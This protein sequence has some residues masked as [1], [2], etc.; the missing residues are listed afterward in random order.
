[1]A[2][3]LHHHS[4]YLKK[5]KKKKEYRIITLPC[6]SLATA[7]LKSMRGAWRNALKPNLSMSYDFWW[8]NGSWKWKA[9]LQRVGLPQIFFFFFFLNQHFVCLSLSGGGKS[10]CPQCNCSLIGSIWLDLP[11]LVTVLWA[12]LIVWGKKMVVYS[13][14]CAPPFSGGV[15]LSEVI[16][17][18][19]VVVLVCFFMH[20][21]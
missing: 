16:W 5:K 21:P 4:R 12:L 14:N 18:R 3:T 15:T 2:V 1:M 17:G 7:V 19:F 8:G 11:C 10:C 13:L 6:L 9:T 20:V